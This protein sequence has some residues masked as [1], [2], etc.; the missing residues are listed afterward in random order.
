MQQNVARFRMAVLVP[1]ADPRQVDHVTWL[2]DRTTEGVFSVAGDKAY[3]F[4]WMPSADERTLLQTFCTDVAER[5]R[6][7]SI[8]FEN[9]VGNVAPAEQIRWGRSPIIN[10]TTTPSN[11]PLG[12]PI[13]VTV[14]A[15][16]AR[17]G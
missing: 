3:E 4:R 8:W 13:Q 2:V 10:A 6:G 7:V 5:R 11:I 17:T 14:S 15:K 9:I 1:K 12:V 16:D